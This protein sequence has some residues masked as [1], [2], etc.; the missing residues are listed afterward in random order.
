MNQ[1]KLNELKALKSFHSAAAS[2]IMGSSSG[3][4]LNGSREKIAVTKNVLEA[5]KKL[6]SALNHPQASL[7]KVSILL[8]R[9]RK[10]SKE[11]RQVTGINWLL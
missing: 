11:F 8:E 2:Y 3:V 5:S 7:K 9:K 4:K 10:A 1:K 6:Y